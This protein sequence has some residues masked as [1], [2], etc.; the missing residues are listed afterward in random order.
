MDAVESHDHF[1]IATGRGLF[2]KGATAPHGTVQT[3]NGANVKVVVESFKESGD[4]VDIRLSGGY[5]LSL[6]ETRVDY[7][8]TRDPAAA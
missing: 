2:R 1:E 4:W 8:L 6:H 7:I 5:T 3:G